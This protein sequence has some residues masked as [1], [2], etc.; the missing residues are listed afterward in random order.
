M[1]SGPIMLVV[2]D[3]FGLG[4]GGADDATQ[5]AHTPFFDHARADLP[6]AQ[7][8][9]S[10]EAVGLPPGQMGNSEVGHMTLGAGRIIDQDMTR[11]SKDLADGGAARNPA[12]Q[13]AFDAIAESGG[14]LHLIGLLSDGGMH[15]HQE[16]LVALRDH[17]RERGVAPQLHAFLDGRDTPPR[18]GKGYV[19]AIVPHVEAAG[20]QI[21]TVIGRYWAMDRDQRWERLQRA[22][23]AMVMREG[24]AASDAVTA[25]Q[26]SYDADTG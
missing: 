24:V 16:H 13:Q 3:G 1:S 5:V 18:S 26:Q 4:E 2:L 10:G 17:C 25:V 11:I 19:E 14:R 21:A 23:D 20:G 6:M 9:T 7:V 15:S 8:E 12:I 22:V